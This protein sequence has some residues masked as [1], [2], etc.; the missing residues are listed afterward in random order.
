MRAD[1]QEESFMAKETEEIRRRWQE[2]SFYWKKNRDVIEQMFGPISKA[3]IESAAL[4]SDDR[5]LDLA[6]GI[7]EPS[8]TIAQNYGNHLSIT[9]TDVVFE[10][11]L[12]AQTEAS[13]RNI[14]NIQFCQCSGDHLPFA[15]GS[16]N[17]VVSRLGIMF[18]PDTKRALTEITRVLR[19]NGRASFAVW[20]RRE[21]TPMHEIVSTV[22]EKF[23][24]SE[25]VPFDAPDPFRFSQE[26]RLKDLLKDAGFSSTS[27]KVLD[28]EI[29]LPL[30]FPEFWQV[31]SEMSDTLRDKLNQ[32]NPTQKEK[33]YKRLE[34]KFRPYFATGTFESSARIIV[35]SGTKVE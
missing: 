26:G 6:G 18:F 9:F 3:L 15:D 33:L 22:L 12:A 21:F 8:L 25:P 23:I 28:F 29:K 24:P 5:V 30:N 34:S 16:F 1:A 31:R 7:G 20:H 17:A 32:L 14:Y 13:K 27:E 10:M 35:V 19:P 4:N 2:S 11:I